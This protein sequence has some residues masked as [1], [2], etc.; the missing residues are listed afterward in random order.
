MPTTLK[1]AKT[2]DF[3]FI[4]DRIMGKLKGWKEK[5][6]SFAGRNVLISAVIQAIPTYMMSCFILP[7]EI[8]HKIEQAMCNFWWGNKEGHHKIHWKAKKDI[9]RPKFNGG[10]GFRDMHM[11]NLA[12]LAKQGWRLHTNPSSLLSK[13]LKAKYFPH[14]DIL[15]AQIGNVPSYTWKSIHQ[16]LWVLNKGCCWKIGSGTKV[17]I[18]ED[19]W[20][21]HQNGHKVLTPK[22]NHR[23]V[24]VSDLITHDPNLGWNTSLINN[25]FLPFE[26]DLIQQLPLTQEPIEDQIM[27]PHTN[28]GLY[29]V[30]SGYNMIKQWHDN[31]NGGTANPNPHNLIWK[32]L[33]TLPTVPRHKVLL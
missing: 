12:M 23:Q 19:N 4:M 21:P 14:C 32:R 29:T 2:Q 8:C 20:I 10:I 24:L 15:Q 9:F 17:N 18:W 30:R 13:C 6:L 22:A 11:F 7:K 1:R 25:I 33:W 5:K 16:A 26:R 31:S 3:N 28:T 27:W